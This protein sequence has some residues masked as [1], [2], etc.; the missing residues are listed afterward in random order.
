[1][2]CWLLLRCE[3]HVWIEYSSTHQRAFSCRALHKLS[4]NHISNHLQQQC[5]KC[6]INR[7]FVLFEENFLLHN[8]Q[9]RR[10]RKFFLSFFFLRLSTL[11]PRLVFALFQLFP[12]RCATHFFYACKSNFHCSFKSCN[13]REIA[14]LQLYSVCFQLA[15]M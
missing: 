7:F 9:H 1:M 6:N 2:K 13:G 11:L 14:P 15:I 5:N 12:F 8:A 4:L 10:C 3:W